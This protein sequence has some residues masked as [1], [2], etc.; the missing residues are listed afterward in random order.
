M[1]KLPVRTIISYFPP[2]RWC[3][4][5][6]DHTN[7]VSVSI[8]SF[9]LVFILASGDSFYWWNWY[10]I[11]RHVS[12]TTKLVSR[13]VSARVALTWFPFGYSVGFS[14]FV[15][16]PPPLIFKYFIFHSTVGRSEYS[17]CVARVGHYTGNIVNLSLPYVGLVVIDFVRG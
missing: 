11:R 2:F 15:I 1:I 13:G 7:R 3:W 5:S 9:P 17:V 8:R 12:K 10:L 14:V 4:F 16:I 6:I